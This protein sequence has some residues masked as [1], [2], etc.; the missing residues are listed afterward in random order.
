MV[1]TTW[2]SPQIFEEEL[3]DT[4]MLDAFRPIEGTNLTTA[5]YYATTIDNPAFGVRLASR[6]KSYCCK[7]TVTF[8]FYFRTRPDYAVHGTMADMA[9]SIAGSTELQNRILEFLR[10]FR[11]SQGGLV[12]LPL[13]LRV[14]IGFSNADSSTV[15]LLL[16]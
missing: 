2:R 1:K 11:L 10:R 4:T 8:H 16:Q 14:H 5:V 15:L 13:L 7:L 9:R 6:F 3:N 12:V